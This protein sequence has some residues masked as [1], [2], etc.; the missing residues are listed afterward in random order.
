MSVVFVVVGNV[1]V[2]GVSD[3]LDNSV[4]STVRIS[5]V[6]NHTLGTIRLVQ[7]VG[8]SDVVSVAVLPGFLVVT[9]MGILHGIPEFVGGGSLFGGR[10]YIH[11][12]FCRASALIVQIFQIFNVLWGFSLF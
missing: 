4:E 5:C 7:R 3:L 6:L 11:K 12:L 1:V 9:G 10:E 8:S 2:D